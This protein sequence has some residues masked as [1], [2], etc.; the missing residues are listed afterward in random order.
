MP[1]THKIDIGSAATLYI[2]QITENLTDL[3]SGLTPNDLIEIEAIG[4]DVRKAEKA[5]WRRIVRDNISQEKITYNNIGAPTLANT[6]HI[7]V[8]HSGKFVVVVHSANA[9][10]GV[11]VE[12]IR[13]NVERAKSRFIS[14]EEQELPEANH[15]LFD[16]AVWCAKEAMYKH[17]QATELDLIND[18]RIIKTNIDK[19]YIK[20]IAV[21]KN[22]DINLMIINDH[23]VTYIV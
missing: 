14:E 1:L 4:S 2:W 20:G 10:C 18:I 16:I 7:S 12:H 19:G 11:D 3:A 8:S 21:G 6:G 23:I 5:A 22:I 15:K 17:S 13:R 9:P